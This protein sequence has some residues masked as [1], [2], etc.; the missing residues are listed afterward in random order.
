[1]AIFLVC[2]KFL[3]IMKKTYPVG[4]N[5]LVK[6]SPVEMEIWHLFKDKIE[7]L[8][9]NSVI[10]IFEYQ[11]VSEKNCPQIMFPEDNLF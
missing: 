7:R 6:I 3:I 5:T 1:M 8:T 9:Y 2:M 10:V 11:N 4:L